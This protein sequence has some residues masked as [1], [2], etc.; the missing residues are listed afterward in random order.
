[1]DTDNNYLVITAEKVKDLIK[2][3]RHEQ[4][5]CEKHNWL[6]TPLIPKE[7]ILLDSLKSSLRETK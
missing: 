4:F 6:V 1:M 7:N 5:E 3:E 2:P